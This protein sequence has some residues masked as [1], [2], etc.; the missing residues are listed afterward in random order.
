MAGGSRERDAF[1][2]DYIMQGNLYFS[3][4][5]YVPFG[6]AIHLDAIRNSCKDTPAHIKRSIDEYRVMTGRQPLWGLHSQNGRDSLADIRRRVQN[7]QSQRRRRARLKE[8]TDGTH[9]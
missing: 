6:Y 4:D 2:R 9:P 1:L 5:V 3:F 7:R 8:A